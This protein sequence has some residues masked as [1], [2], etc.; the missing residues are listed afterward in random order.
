MLQLYPFQQESVVKFAPLIAALNGDDMGLGKTVQAVALDIEKRRVFGPAFSKRG[1]P[2]TLVVT[3]KSV[4]GGWADHYKEWAPHLKVKVMNLKNRGEFIE[5]FKKGKAD[6]YVTHWAALRLMPE[7]HSI[8][9]FL[10]IADEAHAIKN[11]KSVQ[12]VQFKKIVTDHKYALS[13][14]PADNRPDDLW[15]LLNWLYPKT[16]KS[17][18]GFYNTHVLFQ[19][20]VN[21][22]TGK[23]YRKIIGVAEEEK[24]HKLIEPIFIRR[25]KE[26][27]IP[28]LPDKY[29]TTIRVDLDPSQRRAYDHMRHTMLAWVG[30]QQDQALAAPVVIAQLM[31]LQQFACAYGQ[32]V[33]KIKRKRDCE[34]CNEDFCEHDVRLFKCEV[35]PNRKCEGHEF[36]ALQLIDPSTKLDAVMDIIEDNPNEQIVV[37][38]QSKQVINMLCDRLAAKKIRAAKLTGDTTREGERDELISGFQ[39]GKYR[40]FAA[41]IRAG[42]E[43]ITLTAARTVIFIDRDWSPS[44]NKQ[45]EDRLHRIGQKN[46]VQVI[47]LIANDTVDM[48]RKQQIELKWSWIQKILGDKGASTDEFTYQDD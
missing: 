23:R 45:A 32:I 26:D 8:H 6:V 36:E 20:V 33:T 5:A 39:A 40:V 35:C 34:N 42:G 19:E 25:L 2:Q 3:R 18:W 15:S 41:T 46:A 30:Q 14:T 12:T 38:G 27:V 31:R 11:R 17:Y 44:K 7:L 47:D 28:D 29:Y 1:K 4:M 21:E 10:I 48:G 22:Y 16:F 43:G 37:F 9:W 13:G 24:L